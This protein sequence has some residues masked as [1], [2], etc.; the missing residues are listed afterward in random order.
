[1]AAMTCTSSAEEAATLVFL[2]GDDLVGYKSS[3]Y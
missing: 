2:D 3:L 1:M